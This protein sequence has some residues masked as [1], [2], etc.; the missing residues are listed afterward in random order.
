MFLVLRFRGGSALVG[1][2][3]TCQRWHLCWSDHFWV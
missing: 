3:A 2:L 1:I